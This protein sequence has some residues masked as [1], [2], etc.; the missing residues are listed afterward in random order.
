M[1]R[2]LVALLAVAAL[3]FLAG[4]S[5][6][7]PSDSSPAPDASAP[8]EPQAKPV[9]Y[10]AADLMTYDVVATAAQPELFQVKVPAGTRNVTVSGQYT[11]ANMIGL[12]VEVGGCGSG[13]YDAIVGVGLLSSFGPIPVCEEPAAGDQDVTISVTGDYS[14]TITLHAETP[15]STAR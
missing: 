8:V 15:S 5:G 11:Q 6:T 2:I 13:S 7:A 12:T 9:K 4:C 1:Q 3:S 10:T 14:G